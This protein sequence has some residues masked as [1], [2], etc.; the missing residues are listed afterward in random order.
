[1]ICYYKLIFKLLIF[2]LKILKF[3]CLTLNRH[4]LIL[5]ANRENKKLIALS[6][7]NLKVLK[8]VAKTMQFDFSRKIAENY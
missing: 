7:S 2:T 1:M 3:L 5:F 4:H 8:G 6:V